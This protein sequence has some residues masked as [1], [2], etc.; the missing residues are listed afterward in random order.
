MIDFIPLRIYTLVFC[1]AVL[2]LVAISMTEC[3]SGA[4]FGR[5][6]R[7]F[8]S[9]LGTVVALLLTLYIGLRPV[10]PYYF[11][12]TINYAI[13]FENV[14]AHGPAFGATGG[15]EWFFNGAMRWF[16]AHSNVNMFFLFCAAIYVGALWWALV[17]IFGSDF[18]VPFVVAIGMFTFFSYGVNGVRNGMASSLLILALTFRRQWPVALALAA[19]A[20]GTH[21]SMLLTAGAGVMAMVARNPKIWL[22]FWLGSIA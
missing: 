13:T 22:W 16:A 8:N 17:R 7:T 9:V 5:G 15:S 12:D 2:V 1:Y 6:A 3:F 20:I 14:A 19:V 18:F 4:V 21:R 11:G 10:N